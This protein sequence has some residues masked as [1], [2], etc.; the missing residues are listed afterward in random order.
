MKAILQNK[1]VPAD[2]K[3]ALKARAAVYGQLL[4]PSWFHK[5]FDLSSKTTTNK[6]RRLARA[7]FFGAVLFAGQLGAQQLCSL[8]TKGDKTILE[9]MR[10]DYYGSAA[11]FKKA[12]AK[13]PLLQIVEHVDKARAKEIIDSLQQHTNDLDYLQSLIT[14]AS[15]DPPINPSMNALTDAFKRRRFTGSFQSEARS[16]ELDTL[17][18]M[19]TK[20]EEDDEDR[21]QKEDST[22]GKA[23]RI[24]DHTSPCYAF[25]HANCD[26][27][28]CR[29]QHVCMLCSSSSHGAKDC[30]SNEHKSSGSSSKGGAKKRGAK[31]RK[32]ERPPHPRFRRDRAW[33]E[34]SS[35]Q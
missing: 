10:P 9:N 12:L 26:R 22:R 3:Q 6:S 25:Q 32:K 35:E 28:Q 17:V 4:K 19:A 8:M 2:L 33:N 14:S 18:H 24:T 31:K 1:G 11:Q 13:A 7:M 15:S 27:T 34:E 21:E 29:Y 23:T 16:I 30:K 5:G 20:G